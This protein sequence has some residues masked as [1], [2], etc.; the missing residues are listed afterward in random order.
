LA[1]AGLRAG[2]FPA[3]FD[4]LLADRAQRFP[5]QSKSA[6][7]RSYSWLGRNCARRAN[8]GIDRPVFAAQAFEV[9]A[10]AVG[11]MPWWALTLA[12]FHARER[13]CGLR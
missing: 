3:R 9:F 10:A 7:V 5:A 8:Q 2:T 11:M 4:D 13:R 6:W 12:S 1:G